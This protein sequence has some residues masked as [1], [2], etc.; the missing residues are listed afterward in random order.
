MGWQ[1]NSFQKK[2][3]F[4]AVGGMDWELAEWR[5]LGRCAVIQMKHEETRTVGRERG[6]KIYVAP[7]PDQ[8]A[9]GPEEHCDPHLF[10]GWRALFRKLLASGQRVPEACVTSRE[11]ATATDFMVPAEETPVL[12]IEAEGVI[13][14]CGPRHHKP[15]LLSPYLLAPPPPHPGATNR[16]TSH[17]TQDI[18]K[19]PLQ[20]PIGIVHTK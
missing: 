9:S 18:C 4:A 7:S 8:I 19:M 3:I 11:I 16:Q 17:T 14:H 5:Q 13:K 6:P 12:G 2:A 10:S 15:F 1:S 20:L